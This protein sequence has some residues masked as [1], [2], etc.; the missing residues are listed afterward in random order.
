[1]NVNELQRL[2]ETLQKSI[3]D[4]WKE[5]AESEARTRTT[6]VD[7]LL[8]GLGWDTANLNHVKREYRPRS[9]GGRVDYALFKDGQKEPAVLVEAKKLSTHATGQELLPGGPAT[10]NLPTTLRDAAVQGLSYCLY[11]EIQYVAVTDG[12][13]WDIYDVCKGGFMDEKR[14]ASFDLM[15][16]TAAKD[17]SQVQVLWRHPIKP[18]KSDSKPSKK[19]KAQLPLP[20]LF[21]HGQRVGDAG[22]VLTKSGVRNKRYP[23]PHPPGTKWV[24]DGYSLDANG[25]I[26]D[27]NGERDRRYEN[28]YPPNTMWI[29]DGL[30][31][32]EERRVLTFDGR[33]DENFKVPC[34]HGTKR[35]VDGLFLDAAGW[36][37]TRYGYPDERYKEPYP[38]GRKRSEGRQRNR[39][40]G[41]QR[42]RGF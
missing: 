32:D 13:R 14:I 11:E 28:P 38:L 37:L 18:P 31:L 1:M 27:L 8:G 6:L 22:Y 20:I 19:D 2:I 29:V 40:M 21:I 5:L 36:R 4:H 3:R 34:P 35:I 7:P 10:T 15:S 33:R 9:S 39:S 41:R 26:L 12:Q 17:C 42:H 23:K 24:V 30:P 16:P 25:Y